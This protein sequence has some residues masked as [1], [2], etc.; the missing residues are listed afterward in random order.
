MCQHVYDPETD[1]PEQR[2]AFE[3]LP[4]DWKCPECGGRKSNFS[5]VRGEYRCGGH[6]NAAGTPGPR[7]LPVQL[8]DV[9][10]KVD[11]AERPASTLAT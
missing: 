4:Q 5:L 9:E 11:K 1:D 6:A 2:R 10:V 7:P 8:A 3:D